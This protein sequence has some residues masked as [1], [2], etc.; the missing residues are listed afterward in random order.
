[1]ELLFESTDK[2]EKDLNQF[3]DQEKNQIVKKLNY[4]CATLKYG[5]ET[6]YRLAARPLKIS[7]NNGFESSLYSLQV[8]REVRVILT[9]DD[10][11]LFEQII[12]TLMRVVRHQD[13]ETAFRGIAESLY[14][15]YINSISRNQP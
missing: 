1:M 5:F 10:D 4:R 7:L 9:V 11:P 15:G 6:F 2:F 12:V 3:N 8:N 14:H 13:L